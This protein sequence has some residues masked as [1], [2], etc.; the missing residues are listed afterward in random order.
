MKII[1]LP[2]EAMQTSTGIIP[3]AAK[4]RYLNILMK[5]GFD[6]VELG[7]IV[8]P[9]YIPQMADTVEVLRKLDYSG[10]KSKLMV[11]VVNKT[12]AEIVSEFDEIT[13]LSY[14][15]AISPTFLKL[16]INSTIEK[17][18]ETIADIM[19]VCQ[20]SDKELVVYNSMTFGNPYGDEWSMEILVKWISVL[21]Q[22]GVKIIPLSN[23]SIEIGVNQIHDVFSMLV[24]QFPGIEF[25]LHL[26]TAGIDWYSKV[27]AAYINGCRRFDGVIDGWG[28][29]PM[30]GEE[31]LGNLKTQY[32]L[33]FNEKNGISTSIDREIF[34]QA[35]ALASQTF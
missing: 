22:L 20:R 27:Y 24:Q 34:F 31:L 17:S 25:G 8:S 10:N 26:H 23:V 1:E 35:C 15:F 33:K 18:L 19:E 12:G 4:I 16:N 7:S 32:L 28:G 9:K 30:S 5:A 2:R 29:C 3:T 21:H 6:T 11:L 13:H 14:P